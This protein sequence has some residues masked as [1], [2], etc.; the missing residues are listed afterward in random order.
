MAVKTYSDQITDL[1]NRRAANTARLDEI[2]G[3]AATE[4]RTKDEGEQDE[5]KTLRSEITAMDAELADLRDLESMN[6]EKAVPIVAPTSII[7]SESRAAMPIIRVKPTLPPGTAFT[8]MV[9]AIASSK[10]DSYLAMERAKTWHDTTP[11]VE[12]MVKAAVAAGT[13][14]DATWAGPLVAVRPLI[15][16]FL[17]LLRPRTLARSYSGHATRPI[18]CVGTHTDDRWHVWMGGPEQ[19]Q[20]RHEGRLLHRHARLREGRGHHRVDRGT[21][22]TLQPV[23]RSAGARRD[24]CGHVAV[25]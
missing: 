1:S 10:G 13:T 9:M 21:R 18:Q 5:F 11:E 22:Q 16:E 7:G 12:L 24:D 17:E 3:K 2:Q 23:G 14:T 20:T 15:D 8:R 4:G 6:R 19:E 25:P